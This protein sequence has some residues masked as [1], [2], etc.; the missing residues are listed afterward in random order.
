MSHLPETLYLP[1]IRY[2]VYL[3]PLATKVAKSRLVKDRVYLFRKPAPLR[4]ATGSSGA[5]RRN[6]DSQLEEGIPPQTP[7]TAPSECLGPD[8]SVQS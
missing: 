5:H 3:I 4:A 6:T 7:R 2:K 1:G 8:P